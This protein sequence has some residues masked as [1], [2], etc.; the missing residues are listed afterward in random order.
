[1]SVTAVVGFVA[2]VVLVALVA[3]GALVWTVPVRGVPPRPAGPWPV[4]RYTLG[5]AV[6][7]EV[8][9][10]KVKSTWPQVEEWAVA[11][12]QSEE[13][14]EVYVLRG[15]VAWIWEDGRQVRKVTRARRGDLSAGVV[16]PLD[17]VGWDKRA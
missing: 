1:M 12:S 2:A 17:D 15:R 13:V 11:R 10:R 6:G 5:A 8:E 3:L 16:R 9:I 14:S 4:Q 7:G